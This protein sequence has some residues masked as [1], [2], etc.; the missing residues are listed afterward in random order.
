MRKETTMKANKEWELRPCLSTESLL[1]Q[2]RQAIRKANTEQENGTDVSSRI[3]VECQECSKKFWTASMLPE[4]PKCGG[5]DIEIALD[6]EPI[7]LD[8]PR[9]MLTRTESVVSA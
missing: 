6:V 5:T 2:I 7:S 3:G 4:C 1:E 8:K 9:A